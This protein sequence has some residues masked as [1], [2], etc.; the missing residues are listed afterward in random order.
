MG[1]VDC[2]QVLV[3]M[4]YAVAIYLSLKVIQ[5]NYD[6]GLGPVFQTLESFT[7]FTAA[8]QGTMGSPVAA[9]EGVKADA[10]PQ[11][12]QGLGRTPS[13]CYPQPT[14]KAQD[15][16]PKEDSQAI[17]DFNVAKPVGE[18]ILKGVN[19]LD[20]GYHVGVNTVGQSLRNANLQLR[21]EPPNPQVQVSPF[22]NSTI[23]PDLTRKP[24]EEGEGCAAGAPVP[25][26]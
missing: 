15:L 9:S 12:V 4:A 22:L 16:L 10:V 8:E 2:E 26:A 6:I 11:Q 23:G 18:G 5:S 25:G 7:D 17:Q 20:A 19:L 21:S 3:G 14:L 24:L 13:S 1:S